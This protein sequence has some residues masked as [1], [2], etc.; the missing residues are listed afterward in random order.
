MVRCLAIQKKPVNTAGGDGKTVIAL[1][2]DVEW[3]VR[4]EVRTMWL[5]SSK[6][7]GLSQWQKKTFF[8][9]G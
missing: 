4:S 3:I 8:W 9:S 6:T 5:T 1:A 7:G 2:F